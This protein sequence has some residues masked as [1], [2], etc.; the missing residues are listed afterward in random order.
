M[1]QSFY[2]SDAWNVVAPQVARNYEDS[3]AAAASNVAINK[4]WMRY[5][6]RNTIGELAPF[7]LIPNEQDYGPPQY[8][9]PTDFHGLRQCYAVLTNDVQPVR[10][11]LTVVKELEL[12]RVRG[13]PQSICFHPSVEKFRIHPQPAENMGTPDWVIEGTY[14]KKPIKI[15]PAT[16]MNTLIPWDDVYFDVFCC[17]LK[18]A[19][20]DIQ[21]DQRAGQVQLTKGGAVNYTGQMAILHDKLNGMA[22]DENL[23]LGHS[24][25]SPSQPLVGS[26][27][28]ITYYPPSF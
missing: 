10:S 27:L 16:L 11:P 24:V 5:D 17:A 6:W 4:I 25:I 1:A 28:S 20:W 8:A 19:M 7:Y 26:P 18:W 2:I 15:T 23:N 14:K 3:F 22:A 9:I 12:T 21:G 13:I